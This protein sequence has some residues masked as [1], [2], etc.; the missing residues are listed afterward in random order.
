MTEAP[1]SGDTMN[2][3]SRGTGGEDVK[4]RDIVETVKVGDDFKLDLILPIIQEHLLN[5]QEQLVKLNLL[6]VV[7]NQY[8]DE[9]IGDD[10]TETD[11]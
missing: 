9:S 3:S 7:T 4:D 8:A 11:R 6:T 10:A 1:N 2:C 5:S